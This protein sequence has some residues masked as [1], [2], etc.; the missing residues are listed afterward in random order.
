M[1]IIDWGIIV[2]LFFST[3]TGLWRGAVREVLSLATWVL[4]IYLAFTFYHHLMS[5]YGSFT[6][7]HS[8]QVCFSFLTILILV[9][10]V[11]DDYF[12]CAQ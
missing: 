3:L 1:T 6:Q 10:I 11:G 5:F 4:A 12:Q 9:L 2:I 8:V 7:H